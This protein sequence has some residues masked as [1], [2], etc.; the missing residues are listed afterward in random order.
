M[1]GFSRLQSSKVRHFFRRARLSIWRR[2]KSFLF[3]TIALLSITF[4]LYQIFTASPLA[5][6]DS[7]L[8]SYSQ[9]EQ[10]APMSNS[11]RAV[12][13]TFV[14]RILNVLDLLEVTHF[15]CYD[16]LWKALH[17]ETAP[18]AS[19]S[20]RMIDSCFNLCI[21]NDDLMKHD[22]SLL[23]RR[24]R[25]SGIVLKYEHGDGIYR[26]TPGT[27]IYSEATKYEDMSLHPELF[28]IHA[29]VH[30]FEKDN[31][32]SEAMYLR[33]GWKNRILPS[34]MCTQ[35]H[36]FPASLVDEKPLPKTFFTSTLE[37]SVPHE[38]IELQKYH[39]SSDWWDL[40]A[41]SHNDC[42]TP[43]ERQH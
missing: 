23:E 17:Q 41:N 24:F 9:T 14:G 32:Q 12:F 11:T 43:T 22:S 8:A 10:C 36:C 4:L 18:V 39:Y 7:H 29:R 37:V 20:L 3:L 2:P 35:R 42:K 6:D 40:M 16:S 28:S 30:V 26:L 13:E 33:V 34:T 31:S 15:L 19:R 21:L 5:H 1:F 38:K 25:N 27:N